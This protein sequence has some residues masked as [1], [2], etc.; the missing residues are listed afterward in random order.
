MTAVVPIDE[1]MRL[2]ALDTYKVLDTKPEPEFDALTRLAADICATP[3][4]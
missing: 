1:Q 2:A 3:I 4:G